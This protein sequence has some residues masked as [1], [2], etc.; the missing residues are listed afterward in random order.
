MIGWQFSAHSRDLND[1]LKSYIRPPFIEVLIRFMMLGM[2]SV[3]SNHPE[4]GYYIPVSMQD[5]SDEVKATSHPIERLPSRSAA[6]PEREIV[7]VDT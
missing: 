7:D 3:M 2:A 1:H 5:I 4:F 6:A